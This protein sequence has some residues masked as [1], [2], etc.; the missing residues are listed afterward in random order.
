MRL[1]REEQQHLDWLRGERVPKVVEDYRG[2]YERVSAL[3]DELP[4][5]LELVHRDVRRLSRGGRGRRQGEYTTENIFRA[6]VVQDLEGTSFRATVV[7]IAESPTLQHFVRLG[8]R[9][10]MDHTFLNKCW[11]AL[12]PETWEKLNRALTEYAVREARLTVEQIRTDSTVVEA[13]IRYPTDARLLWDSWRVLVGLLRQGK[14]WVST[15]STSRFHDDKVKKV[16]LWLA[17][18]AG[19]TSRKRRRAVK[20]QFRVLLAHVQRV[21]E[22]AQLMAD[23]LRESPA[24]EQVALAQAVEELLPTVRIVLATTERA[25]LQGEVVPAKERVFSLFEPHVELIKRGKAGKPVEFGHVVVLCQTPEKFIT[26]YQV[27]EH[28]VP[29]SALTDEL[30]ERHKEHFGVY[31]DVIA[32]DKGFNPA[33]DQREAILDKVTTFAIPQRVQDWGHVIDL[34]WQRFRAG[35]EGSISVLKRVFGLLRCLYRGFSS[36]AA[37][38]GRGVF[39]HN[40]VN[41]ARS[42]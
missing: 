25:N 28:Q 23:Q 12:R 24:W 22:L 41:L 36:F 5:L 7:R 14:P 17:R 38:V 32:G 27:L 9:S 30:L 20:K 31:P 16:Y 42:S 19:T 26:D 15:V 10:V 21:V 6:L 4:A 18:Y 13:N 2:K 39:C 34:E 33:R 11:K 37:A 35:I 40:L 1:K 29:D 3:L 8:H